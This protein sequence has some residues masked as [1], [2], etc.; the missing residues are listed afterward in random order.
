MNQRLRQLLCEQPIVD[1]EGSI[2]HAYFAD[3]PGAHWSESDQELLYSGIEKFGVGNFE[4]IQKHFLPTKHVIELR[5]RTSMLLGIHNLG[6]YKGFK[7]LSKIEEVSAKN[8]G[9]GKKSGKF[10]FGVYLN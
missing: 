5:L 9:I 8:I 6:E 1:K 4:Q 2:N 7:D 3:I 10:K